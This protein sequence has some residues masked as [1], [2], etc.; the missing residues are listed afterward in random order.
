MK[1]NYLLVLLSVFVLTLASCEKHDYDEKKACM[2]TVDYWKSHPHKWRAKSFW[3]GG[4]QT[5]TK[6][7]ALVILN[8]PADGN[9]LLA[10]AQELI[11]LKLNL[12]NGVDCRELYDTAAGAEDRVL[13]ETDEGDRLPPFGDAYSDNEDT[14]FLADDLREMNEG[15]VSLSCCE[16]S[17]R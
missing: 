1:R 17:K 16:K 15:A 13:M 9:E 2:Q 8:T 4:D 11:A 7:E 14:K 6:E 3:L 10:L 12:A 5:Y